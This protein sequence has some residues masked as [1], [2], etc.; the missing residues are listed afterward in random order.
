MQFGFERTGRYRKG[1]DQAVLQ[2]LLELEK[3]PGHLVNHRVVLAS[4]TH[5]LYL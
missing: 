2:G 5:V 1:I 3:A 4:Y